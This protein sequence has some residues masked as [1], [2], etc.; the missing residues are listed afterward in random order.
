MEYAEDEEPEQVVE[1]VLEADAQIPNI[2]VPRSSDG[3]VSGR[4]GLLSFTHIEV[5][6][7]TCSMNRMTAVGRSHTNVLQG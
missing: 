7:W 2:P 1:Q 5:N 4:H 6:D 3:S